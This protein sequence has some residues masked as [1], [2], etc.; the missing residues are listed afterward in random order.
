MRLIRIL[1]LNFIRSLF[2]K[3]NLYFELT[4]FFFCV[5]VFVLSGGIHQ[6][7][8]SYSDLHPNYYKTT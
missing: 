5:C 2:G 4:R 6:T 8:P 7:Q 3:D 1:F